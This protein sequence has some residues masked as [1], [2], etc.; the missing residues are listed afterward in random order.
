MV[1]VKGMKARE[2]VE[3]LRKQKCAEVQGSRGPHDKWVCPCQGATHTANIPRHTNVSPGVV[4]D[5]IK[6]L[7]CLPEG[8][9]Q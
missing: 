7:A 6:R 1:M 2:V 4:R 8:W 5:I 9:L 3:A